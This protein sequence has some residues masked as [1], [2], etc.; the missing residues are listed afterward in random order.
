MT[1]GANTFTFPSDTIV[2]VGKGTVVPTA[3][4]G[5]S[6]VPN[7]PLTLVF[8]D[9]TV[10]FA[11]APAPSKETLEA[12]A[13]SLRQLSAKLAAIKTSAP[14]AVTIS[15]TTPPQLAPFTPQSLL[16]GPVPSEVEGVATIPV[17]K[18]PGF[19]ARIKRWF[20]K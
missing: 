16:A 18:S 8:P 15:S 4:L 20:S 1:Q 9:G 13:Q 10:A 3:Y 14:V 2:A 19:F 17:P 5:F 6:P 11:A 7:F 12:M